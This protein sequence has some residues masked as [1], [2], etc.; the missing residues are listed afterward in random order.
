[1]VTKVLPEGYTSSKGGECSGGDTD[2]IKAGR[3][4]NPEGYTAGA[5]AIKS[6]LGYS[7]KYMS[8]FIQK[9]ATYFFHI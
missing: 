9:T 4:R 3:L 6:F 8:F 2:S 1:M 5:T 7:I